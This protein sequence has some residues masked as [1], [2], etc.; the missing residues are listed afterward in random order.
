M[1]AHENI[2]ANTHLA[3]RR[4]ILTALPIASCSASHLKDTVVYWRASLA[5][6]CTLGRSLFGERCNFVPPQA[7]RPQFGHY[8][9]RRDAVREETGHWLV[10]GGGLGEP[11][12]DLAEGRERRQEN[13]L[14]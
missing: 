9:M 4:E 1:Q 12:G 8:R 13:I 5:T 14:A 6:S 2:L 7:C 11:L 3:V 10:F